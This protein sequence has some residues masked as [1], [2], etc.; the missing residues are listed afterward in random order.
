MS[1]EEVGKVRMEQCICGC[2]FKMTITPDTLMC[3]RQDTAGVLIKEIGPLAPACKNRVETKARQ[4]H[5]DRKLWFGQSGLV[6]QMP[7]TRPRPPKPRLYLVH[8]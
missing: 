5:P 3:Y 8:P 4:E 6:G 2:G 1:L 7:R